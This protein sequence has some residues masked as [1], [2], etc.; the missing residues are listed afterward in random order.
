M[1]CDQ[2][3]SGISLKTKKGTPVIKLKNFLVDNVDDDEEDC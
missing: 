1:Q 3:I 2:K